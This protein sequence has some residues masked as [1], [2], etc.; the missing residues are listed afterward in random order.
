M[1]DFIVD[2]FDDGTINVSLNNRNVPELRISRD[3]SE[4]VEEHTKNK[5]NQ[6]KEQKRQSCF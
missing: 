5:A 2:T 3:F 1:P 6:S 4:L